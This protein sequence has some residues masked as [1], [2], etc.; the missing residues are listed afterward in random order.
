MPRCNAWL[1]RRRSSKTVGDGVIIFGGK[2]FGHVRVTTY[3]IATLQG[4]NDKACRSAS[5]FVPGRPTDFFFALCARIT[6]KRFDWFQCF[7]KNNWKAFWTDY[8]QALYKI[9]GSFAFLWAPGSF[10]QIKFCQKVQ[11]CIEMKLSSPFS[12]NWHMTLR[13]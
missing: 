8:F 7:K 4:V 5:L 6:R 2:M 13:R 10:P 11:N 1:A 12:W 3:Y 9:A